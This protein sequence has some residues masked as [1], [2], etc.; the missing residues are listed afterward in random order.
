MG[1]LHE[2]RPPP[3]WAGDVSLGVDAWTQREEPAS[4]PPAVPADPV[5]DGRQ[6]LRIAPKKRFNMVLRSHR[7]PRVKPSTVYT[8][9]IKVMFDSEYGPGGVSLMRDRIGYDPYL[10]ASECKPKTAPKSGGFREF[11]FTRSPS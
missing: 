3:D 9:S 2:D 4:P 11:S 6:S 8:M 5:A 10:P 1:E 7:Y